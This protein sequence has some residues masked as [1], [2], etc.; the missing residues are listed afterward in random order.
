M[1]TLVLR[2]TLVTLILLT[3]KFN[4]AQ[5]YNT[6]NTANKSIINSKESRAGLVGDPYLFPTYQKAF[7]KFGNQNSKSAIY[8]IK[9]DQLEDVLAVKGTGTEEYSFN[10]P[11]TEFKFEESGRLFR[12]GFGALGKATEKSFYEVIYDGKT[13]L[14]RRNIK[15]ILEGKEYNSATVTRK[16]EGDIANFV[17]REDQKLIPVKINEKSIVAALAKPELSKYIKDNKLNLKEDAD[18][19]KL[20]TY[21]DSL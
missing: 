15:V 4:Y 8:E 11:V 1:K 14:I 9:Y 6:V 13:K 12:S 20:F 10:D 17:V 21:Y 16:V 18:L 3:A 5:V 2:G 19:V 7:V